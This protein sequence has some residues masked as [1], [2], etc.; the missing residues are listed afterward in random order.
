MGNNIVRLLQNKN[1]DIRCLVRNNTD[2]LKGLRC[3]IYK[4]DVRYKETLSE[5]FDVKNYK[6]VY[7]IHAASEVYIK[8][9][10]S[11]EVYDTN[12]NGAKNVIEYSKKINAKLIYVS[13]VYSILPK[14]NN[15]IMNEVS[16]YFP[17]KVN[18]LYA[19]TKATVNNMILN[20]R[21]LNGVIV[22]PS[23]LV[24]P[25]DYGKN[26]LNESIKM[27]VKRRIPVTIKGGYDF[28]DVRDVSTA[29]INAC[30][31]SKSKVYILS[32]K[33]YS[34]KDLTNIVY[35]IKG[36]KGINLEINTSLIKWFTY[37][38]ESDLITKLSLETLNTNS[39]FSHELASKEL[40]YNPRNI[41]E[42]ITC[43]IKENEN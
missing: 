40:D 42:T 13:S 26:F 19:K 18:G 12:V 32:N 7:V 8:R 43:V 36:C 37:I 3:E 5:L 16:E 23:S 11:K 22:L 41:E 6:N 17:D 14:E 4:G 1:S 2:A 20:D 9:K 21:E 38:H 31:Y 35:K 39:N 29:I 28:V 24:G 27:M 25:N 30:K 33:Y 10:F 15:E 34:I